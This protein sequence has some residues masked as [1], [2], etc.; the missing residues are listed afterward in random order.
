MTPGYLPTYPAGAVD[1]ETWNRL[2]TIS[3]SVVSDILNACGVYGHV[4]RA[5]IQA[6]DPRM[7]ICGIARTMST[8][9]R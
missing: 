2:A 3:P 8:R 4:M 5:D 1:Q 9:P 6:L 7:R